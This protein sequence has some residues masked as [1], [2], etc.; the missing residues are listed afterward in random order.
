[1]GLAARAEEPDLVRITIHK[2]VVK[3]AFD[4]YEDLTKHP[5]IVAPDMQALVSIDSKGD[6]SRE[7]AIALIRTTL[8]EHYGIELRTTEKGETLAAWSKDPKYPRHTDEPETEAERKATQ[9]G[10]VRPIPPP[11]Q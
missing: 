10:H 7:A 9:K 6:I 5:V 4:L 1:M 11:N 8:L 3:A 2:T